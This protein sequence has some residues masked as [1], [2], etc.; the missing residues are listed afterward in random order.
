[1]AMTFLAV[2]PSSTPTTSDDEYRRS[3]EEDRRSRRVSARSCSSEAMTAAVA[4]PW[5][6]S[7]AK[8]GPDSTA[9]W[10]SRSAAMPS[11]KVTWLMRVRVS[12]SMPLVAETTARGPSPTL[13]RNS[14]KTWRKP[15]DG[16]AITSN[17]AVSS[18]S[19]S[20][21]GTTVSGSST[22]GRYSGFS[23]SRAI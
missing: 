13:C 10:S 17:E 23:R 15:W 18:S 6:S 3:V 11:S 1:M 5:T 12:G 4:A 14:R 7:T 9:K 21:V 16:T 8:L 20:A 2:P 22:P 19:R